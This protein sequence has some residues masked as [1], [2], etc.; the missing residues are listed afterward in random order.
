M[1]FWK[2]QTIAPRDPEIVLSDIRQKI[3]SGRKLHVDQLTAEELAAVGK[4][5]AQGTARFGSAAC[6]PV[7]EARLR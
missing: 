4:L 7:V 6:H 5:I 3:L 1:A 2:R